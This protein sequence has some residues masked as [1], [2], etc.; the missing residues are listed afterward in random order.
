MGPI[1][2]PDDI[3][4]LTILLYEYYYLPIDWNYNLIL[5][6]CQSVYGGGS[7]TQFMA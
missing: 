2:Y 7:G 1:I 4:F 5:I 6:L 3:L